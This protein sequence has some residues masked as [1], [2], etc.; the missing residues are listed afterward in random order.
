[1]RSVRKRPGLIAATAVVAGSVFALAANGASSA[2]NTSAARS[3]HAQKVKGGTATFAEGAQAPPNYIFPFEGLQFFSVQNINQ[4]QYLL[5][6]PLFW[7]G[8]NG[9]PTL[10]TSI[11]LAAQPTY[12]NGSKT[13]TVDLKNYS[14]S[15]G[16]KVTAHD[17][18]FWM[19]MLKVEKGSWAGYA[20]GTMPDDVVSIT[21]PTPT[22]VVFNLNGPVNSY[23]FTYN[24]LSQITPLPMA[25]DIA[26]SGQKAGSQSCGT[27]SYA[28]VTVKT[29][30]V[31]GAPSVVP[32]SAAAKSCA[33]VYTFLSK[34][35][36][37]DPANP[38][39]ANNSLSTYATNPLWQ[40]VDGP[41]H[42]SAFTTSGQA[43]FVPNKH[44]SGPV[45]PTLSKFVELP[46]T[47]ASAEFNA[48]VGGKLNY[49]YIH[50]D[51]ITSAAKS[52]TQPG[53]NNP[54]LGSFNIVPLYGWAINYFPYNF[55]STAGV[56]GH[57]GQLFRQLYFRQA[58]QYLVDQPLYLKKIYKNYGVGTY[59]PVPVDP[60]TPFASSYEKS[61]P[62]PY[63]PKK[64]VSL[65]KAH[66]WDVKA[67]G[68]ST[69]TDAAKCGVPAGSPL[70][71]TLQYVN[72]SASEQELMT[73]EKSSWASA[74]INVT[75]TSGSFNTVIGS[76]LPTNKGWDFENWG[77]GWIY[78]PDFYPTGEL[79]FQ[80]G[81]GSNAGGY[82]NAHNDA[83][84]A[85]TDF[86][87][88]L[89]NMMQ[90]ENYLANQLPVVFQ[91]NVA[92]PIDEIQKSLKGATPLNPLQAVTPENWYFTK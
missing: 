38:K 10:N 41:W 65:L 58:F 27:A 23:W 29:V 72:N 15:N 14:W 31:K 76:A 81:A 53:A 18:L 17:V 13:V 73:A 83:L 59:G 66:G 87:P 55:N 54:R 44:Y 51:E 5:F 48:L 77:A 36:G 85:A 2:A 69:C 20:A 39:G 62:Y 70:S 40:V 52:V 86:K 74:G 63:N 12:T 25:W 82:S 24:E 19:N 6:R 67:N 89:A 7:F 30:T 75:L 45:K 64:A 57:A 60:T 35:S 43:T 84:I 37:Y 47:S 16:E 1:M 42:L 32:V 91:P 28:A 9:Q 68:T 8:N 71:F 78:A 88:G 79:L 26:A 46:F 90:W 49:G 92:N 50:A 33:A 22:K 34:E 3:S 11:S 4:F 61:N 80:T 21:T 56:G